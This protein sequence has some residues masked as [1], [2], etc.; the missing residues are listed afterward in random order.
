MRFLKGVMI[1]VPLQVERITGRVDRETE[2]ST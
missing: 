2:R 1:G